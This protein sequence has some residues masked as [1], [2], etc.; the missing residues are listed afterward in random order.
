MPNADRQKML[1]AVLV[2]VAMIAGGRYLWP[3]IGSGGVG[4][5]PSGDGAADLGR[6]ASVAEL[7]LSELEATPGHFQLGRD[8]FRFAAAKPPPPPPRQQAP[9]PVRQRQQ[10]PKPS[11]QQA[12]QAASRKPTPPP[13]DVKYLGSFGPQERP[14]GVFSDGAD[15]YNVREG[16]V[17]KQHFVVDS[18]GFESVDIK[19]VNFPDAPAKRLAV[20]G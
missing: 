8:P 18:I 11:R 9:R 6:L 7:K 19:F 4:P 1:L 5:S 14:I 16:G 2:M 20:G 17:L 3:R 10:A 13:V 12:R 15:L